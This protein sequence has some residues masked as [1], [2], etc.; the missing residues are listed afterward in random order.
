MVA[1]TEPGLRIFISMMLLLLLPAWVYAQ[2]AD[3]AAAHVEKTTEQKLSLIELYTYANKLPKD[4]IDLKNGISTLP[5]LGNLRN[6]LPELSGQVEEFQWQATAHTANPNLSYLEIS[7]FE[8]ELLKLSTK[9]KRLNTLITAN[10]EQLDGWYREWIDKETEFDARIKEAEQAFEMQDS[11]PDLA[12][13][14]EIIANGKDLLEQHLRP[15]LLAGYEVGRLQAQLYALSETASE[16]IEEMKRTGTQQTSPSMLSRGFYDQLDRNLFILGWESIRIFCTYQWDYV[17][18]NLGLVAAVL[19]IILLISALVRLSGSLVTGHSSWSTFASRPLVTAVF[20]FCTAVGIFNMLGID[21][22]YPPDW[23]L[24]INMPLFLSVAIL[25]DKVHL[26]A[27]QVSLCRHLLIYF[28]ISLLLNLAGIPKVLFYLFVFYVS[29]ALFVYYLLLFIRRWSKPN[30]RKITWA[31]LLWAVFPL[32]IIVSGVGGYD[33]LA[34]TLFSRILSVIAAT[35]TIRLMLLFMSSLLELILNNVPLPIIKNNAATIVAKITPLLVLVHLILWIAVV[36]TITWLYPTLD[37]AFKAMTS[38]QFSISSITLTPGSILSIILVVYLTIL[39]SRALQAFLL[40][41]VLPHYRVEKG[42]QISIARLVHYAIMTFG[43]LILL[44]AL[45]FSL[46]QITILGGALGVGIG[47]G[48]QAIVNNF[49]SGLIL[50]FE[51]P[52]KVGDMIDVDNQLGEVKEL[53]LRATIVQTFDNAEIVIPNSQLVTGSVINWTLA[54]KKIRVKVPVGVAYGSDIEK[55]LKILLA[56]ADAN[57]MVL[58]TPKP[59][60]LFLAFGA[61]SLDFELRVWIG[62]FNDKLTV[63]S[64]LNQD[65]EAEFDLA[66]IEIPFPQTD[67]HIRS[68]DKRAAQALSPDKNRENHTAQETAAVQQPS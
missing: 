31:V 5:N 45:G 18:A 8:S 34:V 46:N 33:Q 66:G 38:L 17:T 23:E 1:R 29:L 62:D 67:L 4:L 32:V 11:L 10:I 44:W 51:R 40:Q 2:E 50:L 52:I 63:L 35:I 26:A 6:S 43:F 20:I 19:V 9:L 27:W 54:N 30:D 22:G 48:L 25:I 60:A 56:C 61:S 39:T 42:V 64:E 59:Q 68:V 16:L 53:G 13:L 7:G 24:L 57:P 12:S 47:F 58:S 15:T 14:R 37:E 36:L 3:A 65:I 49:V 55:V 21:L 28:T 41:E